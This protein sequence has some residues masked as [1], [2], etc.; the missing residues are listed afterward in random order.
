MFDF[1][2]YEKSKQNIQQKIGNRNPKIA[3]ILG[4]GLG[5]L[6]EEL[7]DKITIPYNEIANFPVSTVEGHAGEL[8]IGKLN[9]VEV[10]V[11]NGRFHFY[12]GY[13]LQEVTFPIRVFHLLGIEKLLITNAA[14]AINTNF[15][16]GDFM[17]ITDYLSFFADSV[18]RGKNLEEFGER[19]PDMSQT[20][21]K[22]LTESLKKVIEK[23]MGKAHEGV[24]AYMKGPTFETPAEIRALRA[25]GADAVGMSTVPEAIVAH[26]CG[27]ETVAVSC[28]TNMAAGVL[29][30][31]LSHQDVQKIAN[32]NKNKWKEI[33]K[34]Y[35]LLI[36]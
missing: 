12:E 5:I 33:V 28:M 20:F 19:F 15:L 34:E 17:V 26:H 30:Q 4:S 13:S 32:Q 18:L 35:I 7:E 14:G 31:N 25:L 24:Y 23:Q 21:D 1:Q 2:Q 22:T 11:M 36:S 10:L 3:I 9:G 8:I 16:P 29:E 6:G 27:M